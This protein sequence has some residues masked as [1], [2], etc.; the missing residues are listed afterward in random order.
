M[1]GSGL[2]CCPVEGVGLYCFK[3]VVSVAQSV[4]N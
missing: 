4:N 3:V 1:G 2:Q